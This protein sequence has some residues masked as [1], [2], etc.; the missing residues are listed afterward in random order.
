M[1]DSEPARFSALDRE[2]FGVPTVK[3][4]LSAGSEAEAALEF[5]RRNG[6]R[7]LIARCPSDR[8]E[9]AR[10]LQ[11]A[12]GGLTDVLVFYARE[13]PGP[14]APVDAPRVPVRPFSPS[15]TDRVADVARQAFR[16]YGGHYHADPR[17]PP[18]VC[19]DVYVSWARRSCLLREVADEVLV[20]LRGDQVIG[21]LT[22]RM[23]GPHESEIP[24]NGVLPGFQ[25]GGVFRAL[26]VRAVE[27]SIARGAKRV[28]SS[29][30][31][32]NVAVQKAWVRL[33][34]EPLRSFLTYHVWF[35]A[36]EEGGREGSSRCPKADAP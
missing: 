1:Q 7:L 23:N 19:D 26:L 22:L 29:T 8:M 2:R 25:R 5:C 35:E 3:A 9:A 12:G 32:A 17:L 36:A 20:A 11:A 34:F 28:V 31:V 14:P 16:G 30:Q 4:V 33:G 27:W 15:E 10:V 13:L 24:L 6:A 21:F 18:E